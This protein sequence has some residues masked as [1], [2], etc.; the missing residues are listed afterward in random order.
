MPT[1]QLCIHAQNGRKCQYVG[2]CSFAHSPEERDMWTFMKE[3]K[4][5]DMQQTYD[6]WLKKH[7]PG[8]P[9]EGTPISSREGEKQIQMPTDYADI[10]V[11]PSPPNAR[12]V[13]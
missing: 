13:V 7:N 8:K 1:S 2:N 10:M 6:M 4:I 12:A 9:G 11:T 3:N 5:L